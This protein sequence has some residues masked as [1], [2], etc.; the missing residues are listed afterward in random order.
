MWVA[1]NP[2]EHELAMLKLRRPELVNTDALRPRTTASVPQHHAVC[3]G[4]RPIE[5]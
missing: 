1:M 4:R 5:L 3:V 2:T